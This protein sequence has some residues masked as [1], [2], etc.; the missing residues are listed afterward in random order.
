MTLPCPTCAG[1]GEVQIFAR[2]GT[3]TAYVV[4]CPQCAGFGAV[5]EQKDMLSDEEPT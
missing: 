2:D 3:Q 4:R 5:G 1:E